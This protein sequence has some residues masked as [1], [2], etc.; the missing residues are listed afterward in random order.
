MAPLGVGVDGVVVG[1][2]V[3]ALE[4]RGGTSGGGELHSDEVADLVLVSQVAP[5][6][7]GGGLDFDEDESLRRSNLAEARLR[8]ARL[9]RADG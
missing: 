1:C 8:S 4:P 9:T 7:V 5:G 3:D 6:D 2:D